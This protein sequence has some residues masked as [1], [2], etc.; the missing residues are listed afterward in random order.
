MRY[1]LPLWKLTYS[2]WNFIRN[3]SWPQQW[4]D[5]NFFTFFALLGAV[6]CFVRSYDADK[7][8]YPLKTMTCNH[9]SIP[10]LQCEYIEVFHTTNSIEIFHNTNDICLAKNNHIYST[11]PC[12]QHRTRCIQN[13]ANGSGT[14]HCEKWV[15]WLT[16]SHIFRVW[17]LLLY[18]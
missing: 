13:L 16:Y 3:T 5:S 1:H 9:W 15:Y 4:D 8:F 6:I 7:S 10:S 17:S 2:L 18:S 11:L 12:L 14:I